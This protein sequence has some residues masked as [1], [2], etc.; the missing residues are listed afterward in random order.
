MHGKEIKA[1]GTDTKTDIG[2]TPNYSC[3]LENV[4]AIDGS[5]A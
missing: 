2:F 1:F 3:S 4:D 5:D